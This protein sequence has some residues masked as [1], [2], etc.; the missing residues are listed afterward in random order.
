MAS[1]SIV[2]GENVTSMLKVATR[3]AALCYVAP[4]Y[5]VIALVASAAI[6]LPVGLV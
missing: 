1:T 6:G 4:Q 3:V 2:R 5:A